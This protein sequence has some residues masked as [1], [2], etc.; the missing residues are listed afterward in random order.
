[1]YLFGCLYTPPR[2]Q[3]LSKSQ[4]KQWLAA[5]PLGVM[6][7]R[8]ADLRTCITDLR[9]CTICLY[10]QVVHCDLYLS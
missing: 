8:L 6:E 9:H 4:G 2:I 7:K 10:E 1:M 5:S 3:L